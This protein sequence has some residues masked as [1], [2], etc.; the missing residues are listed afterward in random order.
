MLIF[1]F[2]IVSAYHEFLLVPQN[3]SLNFGII[4]VLLLPMLGITNT[5]SILENLS[6]FLQ[7]HTFAFG[8]KEYHKYPTKEADTR[9]E[10]KGSTWRPA[11]HH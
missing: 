1:F 8:V 11:F 3:Q 2:D 5:K 6:D 9:V 10:S 4:L 7:W